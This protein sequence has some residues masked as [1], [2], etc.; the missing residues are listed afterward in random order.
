MTRYICEFCGEMIEDETEEWE[1]LLWGHIQML[2][3]KEFEEMQDL[4]T[5]NMIDE[6]YQET[7]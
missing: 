3:E 5:P 6:C 4:D 1:E 7:H 2:H